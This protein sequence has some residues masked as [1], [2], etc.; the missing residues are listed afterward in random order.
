MN[1]L[2]RADFWRHFKDLVFKLSL[3]AAFLAGLASALMR[4]INNIQYKG[5][6]TMHLEDSFLSLT[7]LVQRAP[8]SL[9]HT[10]LLSSF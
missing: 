6:F 9:L 4:H 5:A 7:A 10:T 3:V 2:L 1:K 8:E